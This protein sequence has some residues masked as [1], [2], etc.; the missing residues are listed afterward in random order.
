[1]SMCVGSSALG[2]Q[3]TGG[4]CGCGVRGELR[5]WL[6][7]NGVN[8]SPAAGTG[9]GRALVTGRAHVGGGHR[10]SL[11]AAAVCW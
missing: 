8:S 10:C 11:W 7:F 4:T 5:G 6:G 1:M 2:V 3:R 9:G